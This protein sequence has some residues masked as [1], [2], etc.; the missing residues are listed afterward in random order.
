MGVAV[1]ILYFGVQIVAALFYPGYNF[2]NQAASELGSNRAIYPAL[3]NVGAIITGIAALIATVGFF[4]ALKILGTNQIL[5][6]LTSIAVAAGALGSLWAGFFPLPDPRHASNPFAFGLLLL[7]P[8]L[9]AAL[10]K[11]SD[12]RIMKIYLIVTIILCIA[13]LV[14]M[15]GIVRLDIADYQGLLQ[16]IIAVAFFPPIGI[17]SYFLAKCL[18]EQAHSP[19]GV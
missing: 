9:L 3:F 11:R 13:L 14:V 19:L 2:L 16:R 1:P 18:T 4:R 7:P 5:A 15:S 8:L 12:T 6:G 10:W 17:G